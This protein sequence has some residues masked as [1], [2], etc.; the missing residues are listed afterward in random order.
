MKVASIDST[1]PVEYRFISLS[2]R[3]RRQAKRND[4]L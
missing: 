1:G 3:R 4:R 2:R